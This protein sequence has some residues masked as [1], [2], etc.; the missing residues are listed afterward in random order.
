MTGRRSG[1]RLALAMNGNMAEM[2]RSTVG[3]TIVPCERGKHGTFKSGSSGKGGY[4]NAVVVAA[5][6]AYSITPFSPE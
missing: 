1:A 2:A 6:I 5:A 4:G 3:T